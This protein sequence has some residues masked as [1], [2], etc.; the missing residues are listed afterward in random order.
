[1]KKTIK[2]NMIKNL[3]RLNFTDLAKNLFQKRPDFLQINKNR[4]IDLKTQTNDIDFHRI[5]D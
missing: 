3:Y 4:A 1:M 2:V 5:L